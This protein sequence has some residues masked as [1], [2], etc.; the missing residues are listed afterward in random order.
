MAEDPR[1]KSLYRAVGALIAESRKGK[2][3]PLTQIDLARRSS[4]TLSRSAVANIESGR[5]R[6]SLFQ[7]CE[8]A[9]VLEVSPKELLPPVGRPQIQSA[10]EV[11]EGTDAEARAFLDRLRQGAGRQTVLARE[12][13]D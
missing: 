10:A 13:E 8:I 11:L 6:I 7:L 4:G 5:Q 9:A 2:V 12:P 3:P 1:A